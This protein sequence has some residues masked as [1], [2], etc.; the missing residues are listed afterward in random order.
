M[1]ILLLIAL[2]QWQQHVSYEITATLDTHGHSLSAFERLTYYNNSPFA[3]DTLYLYLHA[4]A[5]KDG[6]TYYAQEAARL[7]DE[8]FIK[9][10]PAD[11]GY[12]TIN[13]IV[14]NGDSLLFD[15]AETVLNIP[16]NQQLVS[17]DSITLTIDYHL[18]IPIQFP[19]LG[20]WSGH[21]KMVEWYPKMCVF[22]DEGWHL[23]PNHPL[24]GSYGEFG[25]YDVTVNLPGKYVVAGTGIEI[26]PAEN[27]FLEKLIATGTKPDREE[28]KSVRFRAEDVH[29]F[30]WVC[31]KE[32]KVKRFQIDDCNISIFYRQR[33]EGSW[34]NAGPYAVDV[35]SRY[36]QWFTGYPFE[37]LNIVDSYGESG[38]TFPQMVFLS[39]G[40]D[41]VTRLF[42]S[43]LAKGIGLQWFN[44]IVGTN[45]Q[46]DPWF[47]KGLATYGVIRYMEDKYGKNNSLIK[48]PLIPP[49]SLKYLHKFF[50][51]LIQTNQ[52]EKPILTSTSEYYDIPIAYENSSN[53]KPALFFLNLESI[54]GKE[55]FDMISREYFQ[56]FKYRHST[57]DDYMRVCER[58]SKRELRPLFDSFLN[59]TD[60][61]DWAVTKVAAHKVHIEN[62]GDLMIPVD[63]YIKTKQKEHVY[64]ID[65][66]RRH[67]TL[68]VPQ[69][70]GD[71]IRV[72]I[73]PTE[74]LLDPNYW[75]NYRPR[76]IRVKPIFAFDWPSF[77]TYQVIWAPYLWYD[78]YD[79][80][81]AGFY[82][83]GDRFADFDFIKGG[84]QIMIGYTRGFKSKRNYPSFTYQTPIVFEQDRRIRVRF[85]GSRSRGGD[86]LNFGFSSNLGRLFSQSPQIGITNLF[87]YNALR[88]YAGLDSIDWDLGSNIVLDNQLKYR[89]SQWQVDI[90]LSFALQTLG[91]DWRYIKTTFE[92]KRNFKKIIPFSTRLF[93][94]KIFGT[95]SAQEQLFLSGALRANLLS[96][97]LFGQSGRYSPQEHVHIPADGNM[98]GYQT[99]HIKSDQ[100][101]A[102]NLEFPSNTLI[103]VFTDVGYHDEFAFDAGI[104]LVLGTETF[105]ALPLY[106]LSIS[107]NLPLYAYI[108]GEPWKL[109]W[110]IGFSS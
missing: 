81:K 78:S 22:D 42:E 35:V 94:G 23:D 90:G 17:G 16:L 32:F 96:S 21:Y 83:F 33:N 1:T 36:N 80:I 85:N 110:S 50:Y 60:F 84:N 98:R 19:R 18:K 103:R 56:I 38:T 24:D 101:V 48:V 61:C 28:R 52:L 31:D 89:Y 68:V 14:S 59:T 2:V 4:N 40:E 79:G 7:G 100:M 39:A 55:T 5:Y 67:D 15:V 8:R 82:V 109:R 10:K 51:Y 58:L 65:A 86:N 99:M 57:A 20:Y 108:P 9:A 104:R 88:S 49:L 87:K 30:A 71:I 73:D 106:G 105:P 72:A 63:V 95:A 11:G 29:D 107:V 44:G 70:S 26:E 91:G 3:L 75:N 6:N 37:Y 76:K 41:P 62:K 92:V 45:A 54:V 66:T 27:K 46:D 77:S 97:L 64:S 93:V 53:S 43:G 74:H 13:G 47:D 69:G 34:K 102:L 25:T 12:I